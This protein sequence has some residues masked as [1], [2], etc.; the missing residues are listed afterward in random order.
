MIRDGLVAD[1][2]TLLAVDEYVSIAEPGRSRVLRVRVAGG[3]DVELLPDR[4]LDVGAAWYRGLPVAWR[5]GSRDRRGLRRPRGE[6]WRSRWGGGL[7]TTCGHDNIGPAR[8]GSGLHG[9]F[10]HLRARDVTWERSIGESGASVIVR[11]EVRDVG[12]R[13]GMVTR[14]EIE[15]AVPVVGEPFVEV[16]DLV[17]NGAAA[18]RSLALLYHVNL[19]APLVVPG[20]RVEVRSVAVVARELCPDVPDASVLPAPTGRETEA[21]FEHRGVAEREG[22]AEAAVLPPSGG[23]VTVSWSTTELDRLYQW[24]LPTAGG[25]ALGIEPA[26]APLFGPDRVGP[27]AGARSLGAGE[28]RAASV[29]VTA[30]APA[31]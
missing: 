21:V 13:R 6:Q 26:N 22:R 12:G 29:R 15:V 3:F 23:G 16:R 20:T 19:G 1:P 25:W 30:L 17:T 24:V 2:A 5:S 10:S 31:D 4:G 8:A 28:A 27:D 9:R 7:V 11:G 18:A 14:R